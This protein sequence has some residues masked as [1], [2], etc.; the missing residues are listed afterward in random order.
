MNVLALP[1]WRYPVGDGAKR[2]RSMNL[3]RITATKEQKLSGRRPHHLYRTWSYGICRLS[4]DII[5]QADGRSLRRRSHETEKQDDWSRLG[6][7]A[8]A[9][10]ADVRSAG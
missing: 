3:F 4:L 7:R 1:M 8:A 2:T 6:W 5:G 10:R 9:Y